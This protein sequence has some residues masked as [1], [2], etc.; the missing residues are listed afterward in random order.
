MPDVLQLV[1]VHS[2]RSTSYS[3]P[4]LVTSGILYAVWSTSAVSYHR[5]YLAIAD[6]IARVFFS[7]GFA[8]I[9]PR[10][11]S[12]QSRF[13]PTASSTMLTLPFLPATIALA[14]V[15]PGLSLAAVLYLTDQ[16]DHGVTTL[17]L[18]GS[19]LIVKAI[20]PGCGGTPS[21][22][23]LDATSDRL[24]CLDESKTN[25]SISSYSIE[26]DGSLSWQ[27]AIATLPGAAHGALFGQDNG[28]AVAHQ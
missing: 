9:H 14:L 6:F 13:N 21:W 22:L 24:F 27:N 26:D 4:F 5:I 25:G 19:E 1:R 7:L 23:T 18:V 28:L 11:T 16:L 8:R 2:I 3:L 15:L 17:E 10:P 20:T 12:V